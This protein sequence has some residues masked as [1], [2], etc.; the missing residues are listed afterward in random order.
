MVVVL[1]DFEKNHSERESEELELIE[2]PPTD[3]SQFITVG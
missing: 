1:N 2:N 3:T